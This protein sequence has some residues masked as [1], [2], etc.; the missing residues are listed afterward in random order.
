[1]KMGIKRSRANYLP[2]VLKYQHKH[3][4]LPLKIGNESNDTCEDQEK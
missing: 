2:E 3:F 1:M 4:S